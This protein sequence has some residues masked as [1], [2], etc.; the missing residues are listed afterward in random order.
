[1]LVNF[2]PS[3][4][5]MASRFAR[6][7][8]T[9]PFPPLI[10]KTDLC[11]P[12]QAS[13]VPWLRRP[14]VCPPRPA[15]SSED[16]PA[17][18]LR[19]D[20]WYRCPLLAHRSLAIPSS[21]RGANWPPRRSL[22]PRIASRG[23]HKVFRSRLLGNIDHCA[24]D[25]SRPCMSPSRGANR[26]VP[27]DTGCPAAQRGMRVRAAVIWARNEGLAP[28]RRLMMER[29]LPLSAQHSR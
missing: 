18:V 14:T 16:Q 7:S 8:R 15:E 28:H 9:R 5:T 22:A 27:S 19:P 3:V 13:A 21:Y 12:S 6:A 17:P 26:G 10:R 2:M 29:R 23:N 20:L 4:A 11:S 24:P 1:M 25:V